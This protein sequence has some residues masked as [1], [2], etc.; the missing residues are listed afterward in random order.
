MEKL[1]YLA[2]LVFYMVPLIFCFLLDMREGEKPATHCCIPVLNAY[3]MGFA[4]YNLLRDSLTFYIRYGIYR[5]CGVMIRYYVRKRNLCK[6]ERWSK[7]SDRNN[8]MLKDF[9]RRQRERFR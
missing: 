7:I 2:V 4:I 3:L 9:G 1:T 8:N 5:F 6:A